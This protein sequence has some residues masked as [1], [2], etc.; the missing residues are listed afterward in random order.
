MT[1]IRP[2]FDGNDILQLSTSGW[3][4]GGV[5]VTATAAQLNASGGGSF[6]GAVVNVSKLFGN[7]SYS[8]SSSTPLATLNAAL[9]LALT[10]PPG[11][12]TPVIINIL[13]GASYDEQLSIPASLDNLSIIGPSAGI[14][15]SGVGDTITIGT[16][17]NLLVQLATINNTGTGNTITNNGG[18]I[19]GQVDILQVTSGNVIQNNGPGGLVAIVPSLAIEGNI[20]NPGSGTIIYNTLLRAGTDD[21]GVYGNTAKG[22]TFTNGVEIFVSQAFGNDSNTSSEAYPLATFGAAITLAGSPPPTQPIIIRGLDGNQ[23][24]EQLVLNNPNVYISAPFAQIT[25]DGAGDTLTINAASA[26]TLLDVASIA[27]TGGGNSIV[28]NMDETI[29]IEALILSQGNIVNN[30]TGAFIIGAQ[31]IGVDIA[32]TG[33]GNVFYD[34][35]VRIGNDGTGV[36]GI[37]AL[38]TTSPQFTVPAQLI[39]TVGG[40]YNASITSTPITSAALMSG[41]SVSILPTNDATA[42]YQILGITL[43]GVSGTD[44]SG[45]GGDRDLIITDSTNTWSEIP[46]AMLQA[47]AGFNGVWGSTFVPLPMTID[48]SQLTQSGAQVQAMYANGTADYSAGSLT[49]TLQYTRIN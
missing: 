47:F 19:F 7:D 3:A 32:N 26:G 43:N 46:A 15:F 2:C 33:G 41:G 34:A 14:N 49:I 48:T 44:F 1:F 31:L 11:P 40:H 29:L 5:P 8:G 25:W 21:I 18:G 35:A 28:N 13:D 24:N 4:I 9:V 37:N 36:V 42:Q 30:G 12:S 38:G 23:Y 10:V 16:S 17:A 27:C 39:D 20:V 45:G 6:N 22:S